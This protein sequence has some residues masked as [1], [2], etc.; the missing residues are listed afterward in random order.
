MCL[1]YAKVGFPVLQGRN[2][3]IELALIDTGGSNGM[4]FD[5]LEGVVVEAEARFCAEEG[6][7]D[8]ESLQSAIVR[9]A[10]ATLVVVDRSQL[11]T[12]AT[13][14]CVQRVL[15]QVEPN[16]VFVFV[17][18]CDQLMNG[19]AEDDCLKCVKVLYKVSA[20]RAR[21]YDNLA[22]NLWCATGLQEGRQEGAH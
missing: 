5:V 3:E 7:V 13:M 18:K 22:A 16:R 8:L 19:N 4:L 10:S 11:E 17:N 1:G 9:D 12:V 21:V 14:Q 20:S 15:A 6:M 2:P